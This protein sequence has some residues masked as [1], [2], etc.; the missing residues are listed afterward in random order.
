MMKQARNNRIINTLCDLLLIAVPL[1]L[2]LVYALKEKRALFALLP[3]INDEVGYWRELYSF[4]RCFFNFGKN[5][6]LGYKA[7]QIGPFGCHGLLQLFAWGWYAL[8]FSWKVN[9]IY[10]ANFILLTVAYLLFV[11]LIRPN[12]KLAILVF[13][14]SLSFR[15][16]NTYLNTSLMEAPCFAA[17]LVYFAL[18]YYYEQKPESKNRFFLCAIAALYCTLLRICYIVVL[19]PAIMISNDNKI[20]L[21]L[22]I[23]MILY[24]SSFILLY[25]LFSKTTAEYPQWFLTEL[26]GN[27][28]SLIDK[29]KLILAYFA[30]GLISYF[31]EIKDGIIRFMNLYASIN[32]LITLITVSF[33]QLFFTVRLTVIAVLIFLLIPSKDIQLYLKKIWMAIMLVTFI[34]GVIALYDTS[35]WLDIRITAP[36]L[37]GMIIWIFIEY[38]KTLHINFKNALIIL[39]TVTALF[40]TWI[41]PKNKQAEFYPEKYQSLFSVLNDYEEVDSIVMHLDVM[42]SDDSL[43]IMYAIP[44][45]YGVLIYTDENKIEENKPRFVFL[46]EKKDLKDYQIISQEDGCGYLYLYNN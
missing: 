16:L 43:S 40:I 38:D 46:T 34:F 14:F 32:G 1:L 18:L 26:G 12:H 24:G 27:A 29:L 15:P 30:N 22:I 33:P 35:G 3:R 19:F 21:K 42:D 5:G 31:L 7:A 36:L 45:K 9:S 20:N 2:F 39:L 10:I 4:D 37:F 13:L 11:I 23:K 17:M 41:T 6:W 8:L 28:G 25:L 44:P